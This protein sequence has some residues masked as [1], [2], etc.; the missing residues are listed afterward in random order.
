MEILPLRR[1]HT[2]KNLTLKHI[3]ICGKQKRFKKV[4]GV[5]NIWVIQ[6]LREE[7]FSIFQQTLKLSLSYFSSANIKRFH[8][9]FNFRILPHIFEI[10]LF[11]LQCHPLQMILIQ[12]TSAC[13]QLS[14][15]LS[16]K[17]IIQTFRHHYGHIRYAQMF[18]HNKYKKH[19]NYS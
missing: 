7:F 5:C 11:T 6:N 12:A 19:L 2:V 17:R 10:N 16:T 3:D 1:E 4:F 15:Q 18:L 13:I 9:M 14:I 8:G